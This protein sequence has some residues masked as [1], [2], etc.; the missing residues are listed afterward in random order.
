MDVSGAKFPLRDWHP[1]RSSS[2]PLEYDQR[3][4]LKQQALRPSL[5]DQG[6]ESELL[7]GLFPLSFD[8]EEEWLEATP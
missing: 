4:L 6:S 7:G 3:P 8:V 1:S 5:P 2:E